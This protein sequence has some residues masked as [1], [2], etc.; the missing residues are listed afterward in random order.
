[1]A[2][3]HHA[4]LCPATSLICC[5]GLK[6]TLGAAADL[7]L[8]GT[9]VALS[10]AFGEDGGAPTTKLSASVTGLNLGGFDVAGRHGAH[11]GDG[12]AVDRVGFAELDPNPTLDDACCDRVGQRREARRDLDQ[13]LLV[14]AGGFVQFTDLKD[15][16]VPM[17]LV[18]HSAHRISLSQM[19]RATL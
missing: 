11:P 10:G 14:T 1:M 18:V 9:T 6:K 12:R 4:I 8:G 7:A 3:L 19:A 2:D 13:H 5:D 15:L 17:G 16:C